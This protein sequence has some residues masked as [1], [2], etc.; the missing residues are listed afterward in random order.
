MTEQSK[1]RT[2]AQQYNFNKLQKRIRRNTGNAIKDFNM[3]EDGDRIMVCLSGGKDSFTMLDILMSLQKSAPINF[4]LVAVNL[5]QKQPGFPEHILPDYLESLG[6]EYKIIEEDTYSI[7]KDKVPEGK[8]T[9]SLCSRLRRGILYRTAKELG[10]TKIALGH[11]RDDIIETMFLNMF[12]GGKIKGMPPKL[13][14]DNGE[15]VVIRPLAYC[16]EKDIIKYADMREYPIIPCNLCGSQPN[17]QRQNV[18]QMLNTWDKQFPGRIE[19]MFTAMQNVVPSHLADFELFDF[20]SINRDSGVINGGDIG[21][22]K[23]EMPQVQTTD[24]DA[25]EF[26][27]KLQLDVTNI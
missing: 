4:E 7:V 21:F 24:E 11:H 19:T 6:V 13:V 12:Y 14:S 23:E 22:D 18:K 15:H 27:P 10:A 26:D 20:K 3:I 25:V 17:L 9:C 16:R 5:D 2:K 1:E 8:T